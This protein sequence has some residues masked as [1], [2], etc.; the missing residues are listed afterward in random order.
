MLGFSAFQ[1]LE[2]Y[3]IEEDEGHNALKQTDRQTDWLVTSP[4]KTN[5][6]ERFKM[7]VTMVEQKII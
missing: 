1:A 3:H 2:S 4:K 7:T 6:S 5:S